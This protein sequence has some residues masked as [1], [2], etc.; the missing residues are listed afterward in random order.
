VCEGRLGNRTEN[1]QIKSS[2]SGQGTTGSLAPSFV[3]QKIGEEDHS[4]LLPPRSAQPCCR[5]GLQ[6]RLLV[7]QSRPSFVSFQHSFCAA[8]RRAFACHSAWHRS[9]AP[10]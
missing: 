8:V 9:V 7:K 10:L 1:Q 5:L 6:V 3:L 2:D 4:P